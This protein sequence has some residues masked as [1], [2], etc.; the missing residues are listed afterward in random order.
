[1][2]SFLYRL[3]RRLARRGKLVLAAWLVVLVGSGVVAVAAGGQLQD[4]LTIPGTEAQE[5]IDVL[6][7]QFPEAAG[8]SGQVLF[9]A[10]E[11]EGLR[12][13]RDEIR[14]V[15]H[16]LEAVDHVVL[17]TDPFDAD[18]RR[19]AL[20]DDGRHALAQVQLDIPLERLDQQT[21]ED[22]AEAAQDVPRG[23]TLRVHLGGSIFTNHTVHLSVV[24]G[25]GVLVALV[26]LAVTFGSF[27]AAGM[28]IVTA[29]LGVGVAMAG[30]L[31]VASVTDI[32]SSTP[33]LALMIGLA[34]G[35]DYALFI[36]SRHRGQLVSDMGVEESIARSLATAGSAVIF[37]GATVVIA[38]CGLVVARIP[39]LAVMGFAAATAVA[40]AV[41][42]ALTAVP[43]ML[44]VLGERLRPRPG[45][46]AA[47]HA[48]VE[49]GDTHT[50]GARWVS[51]V[52]RVPLLTVVL[53]VAGLSVVAVP[54]K[55][56]ALGLPDNGT[57]PPGSTERVTYDLISKAYGAGY[58]APLLVTVDIIRTTDPV[59]VMNRLGR[60]LGRIEGVE[61]VALSTPNPKA[62]L[63]IVQIIPE[64]AQADPATADLVREIRS[65]ANGLEKKYDV[66]DLLVTGHTA[67]TI[68]VSDRLAGALLPFGVVVV[69][70]SLLLLSAVFRSI[71]VPVK[72]TLGY[73]LS[74]A[75][76]FGVVAAVFQWGWLA[77]A[78][79]VS[80][81]GPV[82]SFMPIILMGV[83]FGLAM[84]YEVFL[85]SRMREEYV[86]T[87]DAQRAVH[88]GFTSS[89]RVVTAAAV[90]MI[91]VFAAFVPNGDASVKPIAL[92]L[93]V[94]VFVDAFLVRMTLVPAVLALLG[95]RAW[96]LPSWLD[97]RLPSL[98]VEGAGLER[99]LE[100]EAWTREHGHAVVRAHGVR[101]LDERGTPVLA[102]VDC[103]ARPGSLLLVRTDDRVAR[104]ALMAAVAGRLP[105]TDGRLVVLDRVL[106]EEAAAVRRRVHLFE[107]FPRIERLSRFGR[108]HMTEPELVV[109]DDV[110]VFVSEDELARRWELL[111]TLTARGVT[112]V[113]GA[114]SE[115]VGL[116][117][118]SW[119]TL[120][121]PAE[122][123]SRPATEGASL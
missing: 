77:E 114:S 108:R 64:T 5:G 41:L 79:N 9:V 97:R 66:D 13:H 70:L 76:S 104:R 68:D 51:L 89:A 43:A 98:D 116:S 49:A 112:V 20:S 84:D 27:L 55:D 56:L 93:A 100:H 4:D 63:G 45:S 22:L 102:G 12:N 59:G 85:V 109:V 91:S 62:D 121:L 74:V 81:V 46:R 88:K 48:V 113:A 32:S 33:T 40:V 123:A 18:Q 122:G 115:P 21:I 103:V 34:V 117:G 60:D 119:T 44:G 110:D 2:S 35:I 3:G 16:G 73:L 82:I 106:P 107:A 38:L 31:T 36:V 71:A 17:V 96:W 28:P 23:S 8:T 26:V 72:A 14:H 54:A 53:V 75:A 99:H 65:R 67:V 101:L 118:L 61:A 1:M 42:I 120:T 69:G 39:F 94:G 30:V 105:I 92:G 24:E 111:A 86:H 78:M 25:L 10:P 52:T 19:V 90:I 57:A 47:R 58:N 87:G 95:D 80:R 83:L 11:R 7:R 37:A 50:I 15:L 6:G 29:I